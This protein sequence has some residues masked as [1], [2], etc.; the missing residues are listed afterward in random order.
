MLAQYSKPNI[1][2][3][4]HNYRKI[5][6]GMGFG[7]YENIQ[8]SFRKKFWQAKQ[9]T[10]TFVSRNKLSRYPLAWIVANVDETKNILFFEV[11][12]YFARVI[13]LYSK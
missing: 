4:F 1:L 5:Y 10:L 2:N 12:T 11:S 3:L 13:D 7:V 9:E 6:S 8:V